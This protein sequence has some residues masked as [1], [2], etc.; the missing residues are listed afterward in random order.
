MELVGVVKSP[1]TVKLI[2]W[3]SGEMNWKCGQNHQA[4]FYTSC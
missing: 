1:L 2:E 4:E 3:I